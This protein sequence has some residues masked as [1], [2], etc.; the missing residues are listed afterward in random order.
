MRLS[1]KFVEAFRSNPV[2]Y[3]AILTRD[4]L[5]YRFFR[6]MSPA[7]GRAFA[8]ELRKTGASRLCFVVAF[9]TPWV[10]DA[11][12]KGW[13]KYASGMLLVVV[14]NSRSPEARRAIE[15]VCKARGVPYLG[16]PR[17]PERHPSRSHGNAM[18]WTY[19]NIVRH[20]KPETFGFLDHDCLPIAPLDISA[21]M[22][23]K[24]GYGL[25]LMSASNYK[26]T[27]SADDP[28]WFL[29]AGL[30]FFRYRDF[31]GLALDFRGNGARGLDTGGSNWDPIYS[32]LSSDCFE[33]ASEGE[34]PIHLGQLDVK[35][36]IL[37][38]AMLHIGKA[39]YMGPSTAPEYRRLLTD[40]IWSRYFDGP[41][42]RL[43][44]V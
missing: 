34:L 43:I 40:H 42:E 20:L 1:K 22:A 37:D 7:R 4:W 13:Q 29:W 10:I 33:L 28:G 24:T 44:E 38:G 23:G 25:K 19:Y 3:S 39:S 15:M 27:R 8:D 36:Q 21:R 6:L 35:Y 30:C 31:E 16:L 41:S 14:D 2:I 11:L 18:N 5:I 17:N 9:N 32:R 26:F 12:T